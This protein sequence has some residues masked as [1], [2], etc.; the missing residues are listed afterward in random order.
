[1]QKFGSFISWCYKTYILKNVRN[2]SCNIWV[3]HSLEDCKFQFCQAAAKNVVAQEISS[4]V[5]Y[6]P[7]ND[8]IQMTP[9]QPVSQFQ[10]LYNKNN[11]SV[12][13]PV[14]DDLVRDSK[15]YNTFEIDLVSTQ[16]AP[17]TGGM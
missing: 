11:P 6:L 17:N 9:T 15:C 14:F 10:H 7:E 5:S 13:I 16:F 4:N 3:G 2:C 1:M 8:S 12:G